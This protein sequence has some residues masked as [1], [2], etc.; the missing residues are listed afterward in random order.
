[1]EQNVLGRLSGRARTR[2]GRVKRPERSGAVL[3]LL[4]SVRTLAEGE[5]GSDVRRQRARD[6]PSRRRRARSGR[7]WRDRRRFV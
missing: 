1:M 3:P 4:K 5:A 2:K 7:P 6:R